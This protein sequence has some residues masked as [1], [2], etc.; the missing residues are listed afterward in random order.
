[1][2]PTPLCQIEGTEPNP[3][4]G[5]GIGTSPFYQTQ[6]SKH[7]YLRMEAERDPE[8]CFRFRIERRVESTKVVI[9]NTQNKC[10][11]NFLT[12]KML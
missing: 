6:Q 12:N 10:K 1:V 2:P 7:F 8:K 11:G 3:R 5:T 4:T 9:L